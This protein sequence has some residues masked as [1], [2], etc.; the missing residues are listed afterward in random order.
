M[1]IVCSLFL[2]LGLLANEAGAESTRAVLVTGAST[3]IGHQITER[4]AAAGYFVYA[5]ARKDA[6]LE[7]LNKIKNVQG[8]RLDVTKQA[9]IDA[10]VNTITKAGRGLYGLVNNAGVA[11]VGP[12]ATMSMEEIDLTMQVNVYGPVRMRCP[13]T[14][15]RRSP[16]RW[17]RSSHRRE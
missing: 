14:R 1:R 12:L 3:G 13:N 11:S 2:A 4:L 17:P 7:A 10:A 6:D 5:G 16:I 9:D 8:V 15:W